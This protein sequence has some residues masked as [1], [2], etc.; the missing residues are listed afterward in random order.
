[1][2][3][4]RPSKASPGIGRPGRSAIVGSALIDGVA[5]KVL[6]LELATQGLLVQWKIPLCIVAAMSPE[7][8]PL[9]DGSLRWMERAVW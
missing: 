3:C 7:T 1:M 9:V 2:S 6:Q 4:K 8:S 5:P